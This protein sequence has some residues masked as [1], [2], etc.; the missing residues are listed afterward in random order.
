MT[1]LLSVGGAATQAFAADFTW[2]GT[3]NNTWSTA[4]NW[5]GTTPA[6]A[7]TTAVF[8]GTP[9]SGRVAPN[10]TSSVTVGSITFLSGASAFTIS[11]SSLNTLTLATGGSVTNSSSNL[12][13][14]TAAVVLGGSSTW[15]AASGN[16]SVSGVI[17]GASGS[18]TKTGLGLL[19]LSGVNTYAGGTTISAGT[20][21]VGNGGRLGT[22]GVTNNG[23]LTYNSTGTITEANV[24]SGTGSLTQ[25]GAGVTSLTATNTYQGGTTI[26]G[27]V[28]QFSSLGNFGSGAINLNGGALRWA[29]GS[30]VDVS[31]IVTLGGG[32]FDTNGNNVT[33]GSALAGSAP[34]IKAGTGILTL[35]AA[36]ASATTVTV[37]GGT[38]LAGGAGFLPSGLPYTVNGTTASG[39]ATLN[40]NGYG[41]AITTLTLGGSTAGANAVNTVATGSGI[42]TLGGN[43]AYA[44]P[45]TGNDPGA[46]I[47]TGK[48]DLGSSTRTFNIAD[49][50]NTATELSISAAISGTG[51]GLIKTGSGVLALTGTNTYTGGTTVSDGT[52]QFSS[53]ANFGSGPVTMNGFYAILR[54]ATGNT[55]GLAGGIAIGNYGRLDTNGNNVTLA[56][57][58]SGSGRM[59]KEGTGI[60]TL[61]SA[62]NLAEMFVHGGTLRLTADNSLPSS[63]KV[64]V[65]GI[66][67][68]SGLATTLDLDGHNLSIASLDVGT[69]YS[70]RNAVNIVTTGAGTL[71]VGGNVTY[72]GQGSPYEYYDPGTAVIAGK[73]ALGA[74]THTFNIADSFNT[75]LE[76]NVTADI[77]GAGGLTKSGAGNLVLS[78]TNTYAGDTTI[79]AGLLR[80]AVPA[81]GNLRMNGGVLELAGDRAFTYGTGPG[82]IQ[83]TGSGGGFSAFGGNRT[84]N[85]KDGGET[86][87]NLVWGGGS[88]VAAG[89]SLMLSSSLSDST[90][91]LANNIDLN[92]TTRGVTVDAGSAATDAVL[93]G[94]LS[95]GGLSVTGAG[96]LKLA[97][98]NTY[99]GGTTISGREVD[100]IFSLQ[101]SGAVVEFSSGGLGSGGVTLENGSQLRWAPGNT[102][103]L[104]GATVNIGA[105]GATLHTNGNNV[106]LNAALGGV[107]TTSQFGKTGDGVLTL[108]VASTFSTGYATISGGTLRLGVAG[109][110]GTEQFGYLAVNAQTAGGSATFDT[111]GQNFSAYSLNFGG[112]YAQAN[113]INTIST[114]A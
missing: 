35:N 1:I 82:Q 87:L 103:S 43:V 12:Q 96:T 14:I 31:G 37:S 81:T 28:L 64:T 24:I 97:G 27:G 3:T 106:V 69:Y 11:R 74:G 104:T 93:S 19:T 16:M 59:T 99:A 89:S 111:N 60:L 18:L 102:D 83:W 4:A 76:L 98:A 108:N 100:S 6:N 86:S 68:D 67:H 32:A 17:S 10:L 20:L 48:L 107:T 22:G 61:V 77:S 56:T 114:G 49:S 52:L 85:I 5:G 75:T 8:F 36:P 57:P 90:V 65:A 29:T 51:V 54:W 41:L 46:A 72:A 53:S 71:T 33:L 62:P 15:D 23:V 30:T 38:L 70:G 109:A 94:V 55:D 58:L 40:L 7:A 42:L 95:N 84:V 39:S 21:Q 13:T 112:A 110:F 2:T 73:L 92:G 25:I 66:V 50:T 113:A 88:F 44:A 78:G 34:L 63:A 47:I 101:T 105:G 9:A 91:T 80:A 45:L 79:S 26:S